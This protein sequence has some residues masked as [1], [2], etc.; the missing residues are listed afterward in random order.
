M[1][2]TIPQVA[3]ISGHQSWQCLKRYTQIKQRGDRYEGW[4]WWNVVTAPL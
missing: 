3:Q 4:K 1:G 2:L